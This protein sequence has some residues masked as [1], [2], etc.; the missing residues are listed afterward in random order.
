VYITMKY[1]WL[2]ASKADGYKKVTPIWLDVT[3][4]CGIGDIA[5]KTGKYNYNMEWKSTVSGKFLE[6]VGHLHDGGTDIT[7]FVNGKKVCKSGQVYGAK[8]EFIEP[9]SM[10]DMAGMKHISACGVCQNFAE[11]SKG[12]TIKMVA[13]YDTSKHAQMKEPSG[14]QMPV[15]G[16]TIGYVGTG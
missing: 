12:D 5:A 2:P 1:E 13:N 3:G 15:M 9:D 7:L 4:G 6:A 14:S 11:I 16:I 10:G 8:P